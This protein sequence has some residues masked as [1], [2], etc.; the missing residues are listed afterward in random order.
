MWEYGKFKEKYEKG[1]KPEH[2]KWHNTGD[3][4]LYWHP[5]TLI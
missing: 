5:Q 2:E 3:G 4:H 1:M